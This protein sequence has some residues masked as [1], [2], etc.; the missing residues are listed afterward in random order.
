MLK[1]IF[2]KSESSPSFSYEITVT[3]EKKEKPIADQSNAPR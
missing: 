1:K 2:R 3:K